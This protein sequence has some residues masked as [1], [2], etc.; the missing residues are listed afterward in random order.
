ME[1][2]IKL[3]KDEKEEDKFNVTINMGICW[4]LCL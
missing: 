3:K 1:E 2:F 4:R